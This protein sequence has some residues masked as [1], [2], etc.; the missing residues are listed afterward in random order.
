MPALFSDMREDV[1]Q[2]SSGSDVLT[3]PDLWCGLGLFIWLLVLQPSHKF[4]KQSNAVVL[5]RSVV[6]NSLRYFGL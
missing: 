5:I 4:C 3:W 6:S 2:A 1:S